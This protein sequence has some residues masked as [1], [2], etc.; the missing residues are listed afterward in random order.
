METN[1]EVARFTAVVER[2]LGPGGFLGKSGAT[3]YSQA[4]TLCAG[5]VY[6]LG[7]NPGGS[8]DDKNTI[9]ASL[10]QLPSQDNAYLDE[11]W[12][13]RVDQEGGEGQATLQLRVKALLEGLRLEPRDVC[14]ANLVF[15]RTARIA[16]LNF[17]TAAHGCWPIH[18]HVLSVVRPRLV[19]AFGNSATSAYGYL[20]HRLPK[21]GEATEFQAPGHAEWNCRGFRTEW[22]GQDFYVAGI[23]HLSYYSPMAGDGALKPQLA[24]WLRAAL[25]AT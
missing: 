18:E 21:V 24:A 11:V 15:Q 23:P 9:A 13:T 20:A 17:W 6:L 1:S 12:D 7:T 14:A 16:G 4:H 19:I 3:L 8:D 10:E 25:E 2:A 5:P 22:Q